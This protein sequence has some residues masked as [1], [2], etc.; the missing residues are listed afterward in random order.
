METLQQKESLTDL[1][2]KGTCLAFFSAYQDLDIDAMLALCDPAGPFHLKPLGP[3][4]QGTLG[5]MG[6]AFWLGVVDAFPDV[7]NTIDTFEVRGDEVV[8]KV[9]IFGTQAKEF[10]GSPSQGLKFNSDHI[11]IFRFDAD[12]RI[13]AVTI[14]WDMADF[15]RQLGV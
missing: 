15:Q 12:D 6:R 4:P 2:R 1:T 10:A 9:A 3:E 14:D 8:C 13:T 11:F 5:E 7:D